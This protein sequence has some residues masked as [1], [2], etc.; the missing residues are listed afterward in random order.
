M[1]HKKNRLSSYLIPQ[2]LKQGA[3]VSLDAVLLKYKL[4]DNLYSR[5]A[6]LISKKVAKK[7]VNR[8]RLKRLFREALRRNISIIK[9]PIDAVLIIRHSN[10]NNINEA[11]MLVNSV[12]DKLSR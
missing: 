7:A 3:T 5:F 10:I 9:S 1:L 6:I 2:T 4:S 12:L 8:N 11:L